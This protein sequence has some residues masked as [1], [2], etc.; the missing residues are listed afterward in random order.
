MSLG[1]NT[2]SIADIPADYMESPSI[3]MGRKPKKYK[4]PSAKEMKEIVA[5]ASAFAT[6]DFS[7]NSGLSAG[8]MALY[9]AAPLRYQSNIESAH[10]FDAAESA[11]HPTWITEKYSKLKLTHAKCPPTATSSLLQ[12]DIESERLQPGPSLKS[13]SSL[14]VLT[15]AAEKL[16]SLEIPGCREESGST[17]GSTSTE[18]TDESAVASPK[19]K[20][21][22]LRI[23]TAV[24]SS[25]AEGALSVDSLSSVEASDDFVSPKKKSRL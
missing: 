12:D 1:G 24:E 3:K 18:T 10:F 6:T 17:S 7:M 22:E 21:S 25:S 9:S 5:S 23:D 20:K 15:A 16:S 8:G 13:I 2:V 19:T 14:I 4:T 11:P